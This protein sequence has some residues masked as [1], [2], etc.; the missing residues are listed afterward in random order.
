MCELTTRRRP[1]SDLQLGPVVFVMKV[2][3]GVRPSFNN[4]TSAEYRRLAEACWHCDA[5]R[6]PSFNSVLTE[7][8]KL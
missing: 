6:R 8:S 2:L 7:L 1:Y 4:A 5:S 3:M